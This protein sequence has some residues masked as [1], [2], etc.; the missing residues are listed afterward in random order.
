M[1]GLLKHT[2][3]IKSENPRLGSWSMETDIHQI[4]DM[5]DWMR[6]TKPKPDPKSLSYLTEELKI[7]LRDGFEVD[8]RVYKPRDVP[9]DGCPGFVVF[10]GGG[11]MVGDLETEAYLCVLFTNLG[12]IAVNINYRHAPEH[13]FPQAIHDAFDATKWVSS[14]V[15][16]PRHI[17]VDK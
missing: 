10:H 1:N 8:A 15:S 6:E 14:P 9:A 11:Y 17:S 3:I 2:K 13:V 4:R 5:M 12:G 16:V 7:P